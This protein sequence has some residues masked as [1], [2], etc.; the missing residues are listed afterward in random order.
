MIKVPTNLVP[1]EDLLPGLH[2]AVLLYLLDTEEDGSCVFL[3][4][5]RH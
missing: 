5:E 3:F 2:S 4:L 1:G